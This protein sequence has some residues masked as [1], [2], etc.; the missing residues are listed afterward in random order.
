[1]RIYTSLI[2]ALLWKITPRIRP[3]RARK[4]GFYAFFIAHILLLKNC[5]RARRLAVDLRERLLLARCETFNVFFFYSV[6]PRKLIN[7]SSFSLQANSC[8]GHSSATHWRWAQEK[9]LK[10]H[11]THS[12]YILCSCKPS[13]MAHLIR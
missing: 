13:E 7:F 4:T 9:P 10:R 3:V 11:H 5:Y 12:Y 8:S 6:N 2:W 1:V